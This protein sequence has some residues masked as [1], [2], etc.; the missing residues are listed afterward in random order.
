VINL[1]RQFILKILTVFISWQFDSFVI[2]G[3]TKIIPWRIKGNRDS[4][5]SIGNNCIVCSYVV[6]EKDNAALSIGNRCFIG[7]GLMSIA[8]DVKIGSDVMISW[9]VTIAD[10]N[11]HSLNF[12]ERKTDVENWRSQNKDW[13]TVKIQ[14]IV[15]QDK[16]WIGFNSILL[17]GVTIGEGAIV[18]AGSVVTK[19]VAPFTIV[20][21]NPAR[22]IRELNPNE[23]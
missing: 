16:V 5:L 4:L 13:S 21:G 1:T 9:G 7:K 15:I 14:Q 6:F 19:D 17:K 18:G 10:H 3:G 2:G 22:V 12:S 11:S 23:R 8:S 20:A